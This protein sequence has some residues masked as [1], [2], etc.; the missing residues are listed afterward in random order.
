MKIRKSTWFLLLTLVFIIVALGVFELRKAQK[1]SSQTNLPAI[2]PNWTADSIIKISIKYDH[3]KNSLQF[4]RDKNNNWIYVDR[5]ANAM[6][7]DEINSAL[8][9]LFSLTPTQTL[10]QGTP[11]DWLGLSPPV[12]SFSV[13]NIS[14]E[15]KIV[16]IGQ[17]APLGAGYYLQ[18]D[19][20]T[21]VI[22]PYNDVIQILDRIY[23]K[24]VP[25]TWLTPLATSEPSISATEVLPLPFQMP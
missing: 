18:V 15:T 17:P 20:N 11:V 7:Q 22:V 5:Q 9:Q 1:D 14:G 3:D 16:K 25:A 21:P 13:M 23:L 12:A 19:N 8:T 2:L 10:D 6:P 24:V 4:L